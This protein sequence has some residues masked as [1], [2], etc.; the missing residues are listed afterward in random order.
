MNP[1]THLTGKTFDELTYED[2]LDVANAYCDENKY[3]TYF[4]HQGKSRALTSN[5]I[6]AFENQIG[7]IE[8]L[9]SYFKYWTE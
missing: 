3:E 5:A 7:S 2:I 9:K 8:L 6:D 1:I 4:N